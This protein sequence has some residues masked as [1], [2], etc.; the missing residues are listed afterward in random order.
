MNFPKNILVQVGCFTYIKKG[1]KYYNFAM[2]LLLLLIL[3]LWLHKILCMLRVICTHR[4]IWVL[5]IHIYTSQMYLLWQIW[6]S[7]DKHHLCYTPTL[8]FTFSHPYT[9]IQAHF[10]TKCRELLERILLPSVSD[11][12]KLKSGKSCKL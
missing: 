1:I 6:H 4:H 7:T 5:H 12:I 3:F 11:S 2:Y 10:S 8:C 9:R